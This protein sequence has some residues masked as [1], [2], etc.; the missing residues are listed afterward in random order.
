MLGRAFAGAVGL[1]DSSKFIY[2]VLDDI[3]R[4][5]KEDG[6]TMNLVKILPAVAGRV[7]VKDPATGYVAA[8]MAPTVAATAPVTPPFTSQLDASADSAN[9]TK[10]SGS[11]I[12]VMDQRLTTL[13]ARK[14]LASMGFKFYDQ[15]QYVDSVRRSDFMTFRF[16]IAAG[17]IKPSAPDSKG[18]TASGLIDQGAG[19][20]TEMK[21]WQDGIMEL[22]KQGLYK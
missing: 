6:Y 20:G 18:D 1:G 21:F 7:A 14:E 22:E 10:S 16:F 15:D 5:G 11:S 4:R 3:E 17:G 12:A 8:A 13:G 9:S 2:S 19:K